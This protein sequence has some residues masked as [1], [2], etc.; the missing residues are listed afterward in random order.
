MNRFTRIVLSLALLIM[1]FV[2][3]GGP[4]HAEKQPYEHILALGATQP[5]SNADNN[6]MSPLILY[7]W[8]M[9][10]FP[11]DLYGQFGLITTRVFFVFGFKN[12]S[13]FA[14]IKP[15]LNHNIYGAN[16]A[17][18][19]DGSL[20]ETRIFK[21]NNAGAELFFR[22]N[23]IRE[24]S[25]MVSYY[26]G[27][28]FYQK[29]KQEQGIFFDTQETLIDL[30]KNHWE[31][32]GTFE[33]AFSNVQRSNVDRI[34]HGV[35]MRVKY[36][37]T[38][39]VG[40]GTFQDSLPEY[41]SDITNTQKRYAQIG[42][43]YNFPLDI[44]LLLDGIGAWHKNI[45]RNNS[46]QLGSYSSETGVLPGYFFGE[47]YQNRYAIGRAQIGF[48]FL[49]FWETRLQP[50]FHVLYMPRDNQVVG[51]QDYERRT[52][53]SVSVQLS[54]K[55]GGVLPI[56]VHYAY[57]MDARRY[58]QDDGTEKKGSHEV[59]VLMVMAFGQRQ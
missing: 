53:R 12:D 31:H 15:Q 17:Y 23:F 20:D 47:F 54:T 46:D 2:C 33:L 19:N 9:E 29:Y 1:M 37:Y 40:Y 21:G 50:G 44:N 6:R 30:P 36:Q 7:N 3:L 14:G 39:R 59:C 45:D 28:Y 18:R 4:A 48:P 41:A 24:L 11:N 43:Y 13:I 38:H 5:Y 26:P 52:Y 55:L 27:Y 8:F 58:N 57:G 42:L 56:F 35:L 10:D 32:T 22:Y 34:K 16:H 25:A 51:V 49:P